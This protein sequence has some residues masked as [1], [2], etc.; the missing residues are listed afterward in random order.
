[1]LLVVLVEQ[2]VGGME[3]VH[4]TPLRRTQASSP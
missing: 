3:M 4:V 2:Q 1:V